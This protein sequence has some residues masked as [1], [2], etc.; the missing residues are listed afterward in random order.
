MTVFNVNNSGWK[1]K[2]THY[3]W[4]E[5]SL[6]DSVCQ[7]QKNYLTCINNKYLN[8][9]RKWSSIMNNLGWTSFLKGIYDVMLLNLSFQWVLD[10]VASRAIALCLLHL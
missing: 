1:T 4:E 8:D 6:Y 10:S 7:L 9:G 5:M 3:L 2:I